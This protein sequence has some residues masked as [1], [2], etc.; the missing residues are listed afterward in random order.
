M[1]V[2]AWHLRKQAE[3]A[4]FDLFVNFAVVKEQRWR[5]LC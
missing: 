2:L 5:R 3:E 4:D 1:M